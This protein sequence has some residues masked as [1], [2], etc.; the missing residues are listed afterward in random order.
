[1]RPSTPLGMIALCAL[2]F[3]VTATAAETAVLNVADSLSVTGNIQQHREAPFFAGLAETAAIER[4]VRYAAIDTLELDPAETLDLLQ[5]GV[6]DIASIGIAAIAKRDPV[7]LGL[8]L[9]GMVTDYATARTAAE[10]YA[11]VLASHLEERYQVHLL[12][13]WPFGPQVLFCD[14]EVSGLDDVAGRTVRV[15]DPNLGAALEH[16]GAHPVLIKFAEVERAFELDLIN[17]AITG[18]SSANTAGWVAHSQST[19]PLGF[20]I[21]FN[22]YGI[23]TAAWE[24]FTPGEQQR[25]SATFDTY[26]DAVWAY[27][28]SLYDDALRCNVG[29]SPCTTV[30]RADLQSVSPT[31]ADRATVHTLVTDVSLP[32]WLDDCHET[33]PDCES[34]WRNSVGAALGLN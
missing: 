29:A 30:P 5:N 25:L 9:V 19:L 11:P 3:T 33:K 17:C 31:D 16:L 34:L 24:A 18:P 8:D 21:A 15:Y 28:E 13:L 20:Q 7:F 6:V 2:Q 23:S 1:M 22:A 27:S 32:N 12:G 10:A 26:L 4:D 14:S